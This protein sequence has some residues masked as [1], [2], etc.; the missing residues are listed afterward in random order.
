VCI[1]QS[2]IK[3]LNSSNLKKV[4]CVDLFSAARTEVEL[5][6]SKLHEAPFPQQCVLLMRDGVMVQKIIRAI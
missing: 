2:K 3:V 5:D 1:Q 4:I 6:F